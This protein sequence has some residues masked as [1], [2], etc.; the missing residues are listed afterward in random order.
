MSNAGCC[1][2]SV[3]SAG[4]GKGNRARRVGAKKLDGRGGG[5]GHANSHRSKSQNLQYRCILRVPFMYVSTAAAV[6][7]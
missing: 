1:V 6:D 5:G 2:A 7:G 3:L 4:Q